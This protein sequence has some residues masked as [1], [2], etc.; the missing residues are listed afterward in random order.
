MTLHAMYTVKISAACSGL[1]PA[2]LRRLGQRELSSRHA[3]RA[4]VV[5]Q[6]RQAAGARPEPPQRAGARTWESRAG[7]I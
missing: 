3:A 2:E 4:K 6:S 5:G 7:Q 1:L